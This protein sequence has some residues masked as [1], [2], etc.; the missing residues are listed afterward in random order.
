MQHFLLEVV[1]AFHCSNSFVYRCFSNFIL[2]AIFWQ[3]DNFYRLF[4]FFVCVSSKVLCFSFFSFFEKIA[5]G[6][7]AKIAWSVN[8]FKVWFCQTLEMFQAFLYFFYNEFFYSFLLNLKKNS[9]GFFFTCK[10]V[11]CFYS[12]V[13]PSLNG[14]F[15]RLWYFVVSSQSPYTHLTSLLQVR[16][17]WLQGVKFTSVSCFIK[18]RPLQ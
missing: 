12:V 8:Y 6:L 1:C 9:F 18:T 16:H 4:F 11:S 10:V 2:H 17:N 15:V 13:C 7:I 14:L 3:F 5:C